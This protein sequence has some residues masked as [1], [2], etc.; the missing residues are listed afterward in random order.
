[1]MLLL[2]SAAFGAQSTSPTT[3]T[4]T[5]TNAGCVAAPASI[6]AGA[7]TFQVNDTTGDQVSEVELLHNDVLVGEEENL[8]PGASGSFA[9]NV[10]AGDYELYCP[11]P[12][13]EKP[14]SPVAAA[15]PPAPT[16][17]DPAIHADFDQATSGHRSYVQQEVAALVTSTQA[18]AN[19]AAPAVGR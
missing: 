1:I 7:V 4:V 10:P 14:P 8:F 3:V 11:G 2:P 9:V 15:A 13:T 6:G 12:D 17:V 19:A 18:F 16:T 5:V